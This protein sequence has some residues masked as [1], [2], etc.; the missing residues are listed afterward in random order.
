MVLLKNPL[1]FLWDVLSGPW[2]GLARAR[3]GGEALVPEAILEEP[4]PFC[5]WVEA[6]EGAQDKE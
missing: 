2:K 4:S 3:H 1:G 6:V 5:P